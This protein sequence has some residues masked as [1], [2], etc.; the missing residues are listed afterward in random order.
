MRTDDLDTLLRS[1]DLWAGDIPSALTREVTA[2]VV[3]VDRSI[4][5]R[6]RLRRRMTGIAAAVLVAVPTTAVAGYQLHA[7]TGLFGAPGE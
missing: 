3:G 7:R 5:A 2:G 6:M 1:A 4:A